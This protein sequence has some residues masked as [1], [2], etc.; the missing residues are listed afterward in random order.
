MAVRLQGL[1]PTCASS[2]CQTQDRPRPHTASLGRLSLTAS[3]CN[4]AP[5]VVFTCL[6]LLALRA[7]SYASPL[8]QLP[9]SLQATP[10]EQGYIEVVRRLNEAVTS[11]QG[12]SAAAE[13]ASSCRK[14]EEKDKGEASMGSTWQLLVD[15]MTPAVS[16]GLTTASGAKFTEALVAG[17]QAGRQAG[18]LACL[19]AGGGGHA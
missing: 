2:S 8:R 3:Q 14:V 12:F 5:A 1:S 19:G 11:G 17:G 10:K 9:G 7:G 13:F 15:I 6:P 16:K 18:R 4:Y